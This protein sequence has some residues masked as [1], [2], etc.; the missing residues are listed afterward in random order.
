MLKKARNLLN[1]IKPF[2][3][4]LLTM[5]MTYTTATKQVMERTID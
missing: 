2:A 4:L 5:V 1:K 3:F